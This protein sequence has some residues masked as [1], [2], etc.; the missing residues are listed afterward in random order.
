MVRFS[1][2]DRQTKFQMFTP[3][4]SNR[5]GGLFLQ[6]WR[7]HTRLYNFARNIS[8]NISTLGNAH[9]LNLKNSHLCLSSLISHNFLTQFNLLN[10]F[11]II[12]L[13]LGCVTM[14][15]L[16]ISFP[17][18]TC[19]LVSAKTRSSGI[20]HFKSPRFLDIRFHGACVLWL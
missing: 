4:S 12:I 10:G 2:L 5:S 14:S 13:F 20:I 11:I 15:L 3:F 1:C 9:T 16:S 18:P 7:L 17:E 19:P 6:Q 8:T